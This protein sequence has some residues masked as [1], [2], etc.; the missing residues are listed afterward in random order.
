[1]QVICGNKCDL[2]SQREVTTLEG[3]AFAEQIGWPFFETSAKL[4]LNISEAIQELVRRTPRLRGKEY[5]LVIQGAG[6][7]G[8]SAICIQFVAGHFVDAYDPTIEDSYRKQIVIKGIPKAKTKAKGA[9]GTTSSKYKTHKLCVCVYS[10]R[11]PIYV[12]N[13]YVAN[14][15]IIVTHDS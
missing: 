14:N 3:A 4:N 1:M 11:F 9:S 15:C 5:K 10:C 7:V 8:K 2:E 12:W 13:I 6:G